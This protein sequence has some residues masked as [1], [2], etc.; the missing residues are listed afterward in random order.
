MTTIFST[1]FVT[2]VFGG[3]ILLAYLLGEMEEF[4]FNNKNKQ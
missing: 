1:I 2:V 4:W 3:I